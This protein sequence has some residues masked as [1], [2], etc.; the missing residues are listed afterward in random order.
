MTP[1]FVWTCLHGVVPGPGA[2]S[3]PG[4]LLEMHALSQTEQ[5]TLGGGLMLYTLTSSPRDTDE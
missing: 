1:L 5:E 2:W 3:Q 4:G